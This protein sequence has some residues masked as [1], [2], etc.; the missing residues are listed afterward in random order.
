MEQPPTTRDASLDVDIA[1]ALTAR[2]LIAWHS[3]GNRGDA[4]TGLMAAMSALARAARGDL[5]ARKPHE[6]LALVAQPLSSW[7]PSDSDDMLIDAGAPS[8]YCYDLDAEAGPDP[9]AELAQARVGESRASFALRQEGEREYRAFR[10]F[11]T[12]HGHAR[13]I[14]AIR[15]IS[16]SGLG[17]G[18]LYEEVPSDCRADRDGVAAFFP[19]PCCTWP[20]RVERVLVECASPRCRAEGARYRL[21]DEKGALTPL[22]ARSAVQPVPL[23]DRVRLRRGVWR[24]TLLPG[25]TELSIAG[26]LECLEGVEVALWPQRDRYDLH[27]RCQDGEWRVD[28]KDWSDPVALARRLLA[29]P[30][31]EEFWIV[32]PDERQRQI[33]VLEERCRGGKWR[34]TTA[35]ELVRTVERAAA[36]QR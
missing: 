21:L 20:M 10:K 27:V 25:L 22:G 4:L 28:V 12:T 19:C 16:P 36:V 3:P 24:Y 13:R 15:A 17:L 9:A 30:A 7:L 2:A 1:L 29:R 18:E 23:D 5:P 8:S 35:S 32:V 14:D 11:L 26:R 34:F 6:L 31:G 33:P